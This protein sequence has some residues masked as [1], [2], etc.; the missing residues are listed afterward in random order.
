[1]WSC[2]W[3]SLLSTLWHSCQVRS[4]VLG[5]QIPNWFWPCSHTLRVIIHSRACTLIAYLSFSGCTVTGSY[6]KAARTLLPSFGIAAITAQ[7]PELWPNR[8]KSAAETPLRFRTWKLCQEIRV[9]V[10]L[11]SRS[12]LSKPNM[13]LKKLISWSPWICPLIPLS[14]SLTRKSPATYRQCHFC[15]G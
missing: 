3:K 11:S 7:P 6:M 13:P 12:L 15:W 1:M 8:K 5:L 9:Q 14:R 2:I 10:P 4:W